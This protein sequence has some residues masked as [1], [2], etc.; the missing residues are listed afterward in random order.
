MALTRI[1]SVHTYSSAS[2]AQTYYFDVVVDAQ[3]IVS[4]RNI[5]TPTSSLCDGIT[6]LPQT[7]MDDMKAAT[8]LVTLLQL[9]TEMDSGNVVFTGQTTQAVV[10]PAGVLNNTNYR[11][12]FTTPDGTVL[13]ATAK[14]TTGFTATAATT[15]GSVAAPKTV[16]YSVLVKT[17]QTSDLS[18]VVTIADTDLGSKAVVFTTALSTA[19]YR[20]LLEPRGFFDAHVPTATKLKTGFTIELGH[21]PAVGSDVDVGYDVFV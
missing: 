2:G 1:Q 8:E 10:I 3:S 17:G 18:G 7:V 6:S 12:V 20:V 16:G 5:R 4:V 15:Y 14:T 19:A 9:E 13:E 21:V 11:V